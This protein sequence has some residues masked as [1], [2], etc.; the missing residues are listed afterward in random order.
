MQISIIKNPKF[1]KPFRNPSKRT[2]VNILKKFFL[3]Y[4]SKKFGSPYAQSPQKCSN[5]KI[6]AKIKGKEANFF[7]RKFTKGI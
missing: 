2:Q 1:E 5:F 6:Q 4:L 3:E 7:S